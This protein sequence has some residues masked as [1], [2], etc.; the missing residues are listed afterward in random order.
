MVSKKA[1]LITKEN[2]PS[3][4]LRY[5]YPIE[6]IQD[7]FPVGLYLVA[8]FGDNGECHRYNGVVSY[9]YLNASYDRVGEPLHNGFFE[10]KPRP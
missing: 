5:G 4:A 6:D 7:V 3:L 9:E 8:E 2:Q 1:V 10:I